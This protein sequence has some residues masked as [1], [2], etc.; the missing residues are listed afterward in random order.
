MPN[1]ESRIEERDFARACAPRFSGSPVVS[2][3]TRQRRLALSRPS[4]RAGS[5]AKYLAFFSIGPDKEGLF[6][7]YHISVRFT[8]YRRRIGHID[9]RK[10]TIVDKG[11]NEVYEEQ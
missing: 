8:V 10:V 1:N 9:D 5:D 11:D 4:T 6:A 7:I 2:L 3:K